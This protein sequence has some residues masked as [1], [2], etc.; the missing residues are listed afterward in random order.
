[1]G[2]LKRLFGGGGGAS[3]PGDAVGMYY[4]VRPR[5][6]D[7]VV[8]VRIDRNNDLSL[9]DDGGSYWVHKLVRGVKCRENVELDLFFDGNRRL[10]DKQVKNGELVD[11]AAYN[12]WTATQTPQS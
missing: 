12:A 4:Y 1:M 5:G 7:E 8:R 2:F 6:C 3:A 10:T 11:E 9:S